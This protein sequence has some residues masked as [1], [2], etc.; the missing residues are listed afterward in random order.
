[1][2]EPLPGIEPE[3]QEATGTA[4]S[5]GTARVSTPPDSREYIILESKQAGV[6]HEKEKVKAGDNNEALGAISNPDKTAKYQAIAS[7][8]WSPKSPEIET[9]TTVNWK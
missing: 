7:R 4:S 8:N 2:S 1:M 6:W 5:G 3:P 9:V